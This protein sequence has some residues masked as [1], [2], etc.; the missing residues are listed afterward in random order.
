MHIDVWRCSMRLR[1]L[2]R[3]D[4]LNDIVHRMRT[5]RWRLWHLASDRFGGALKHSNFTTAHFFQPKAIDHQIPGQLSPPVRP[6]QIKT[7]TQLLLCRNTRAQIHPATLFD[8]GAWDWSL[9]GPCWRGRGPRVSSLQPRQPPLKGAQG[10]AAQGF[11]CSV[12]A[13]LLQMS[14]HFAIQSK[15]ATERK[16]EPAQTAGCF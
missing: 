7:A 9:P 5:S 14:D 2:L 12:L 8:H 3:I 11:V 15:L 10:P 13:K 6:N 16:R 4:L 1:I